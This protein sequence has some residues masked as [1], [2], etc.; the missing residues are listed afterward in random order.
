VSERRISVSIEISD[1]LF[2]DTVGL[3]EE[4]TREIESEF[5]AR[6]GIEADVRFIP[7]RS[8]TVV[9]DDSETED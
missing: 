6:L 1:D 2:D 3:I 9:D 8:R 4:L 5:L 7:P